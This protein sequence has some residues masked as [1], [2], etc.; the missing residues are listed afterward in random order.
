MNLNIILFYLYFF[1]SVNLKQPKITNVFK[2]LD[3]KTSE[4]YTN[5]IAY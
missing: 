2:K 1:R 3:K 4:R 5:A